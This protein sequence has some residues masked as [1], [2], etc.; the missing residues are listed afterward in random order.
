MESKV[1]ELLRSEVKRRMFEECGPRIRQCVTQLTDS[2]IWYRP[3]E[4]SNSIGNLVLHLSGNIRQWICAGLGKEPDIRRRQ[5]EF[6]AKEGLTGTELLEIFEAVL[7]DSRKVIDQL[8]Y[9]A[10]VSM[11]DVQTFY[12]NGVSILV[13]VTEHLSYH[14]GQIAYIT[15]M[16]L[17][18]PLDFYAG[19]D[20]E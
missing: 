7:N 11:H 16:L 17:G 8:P 5:T 20:L 9:E 10:F 6:D 4:E 1:T 13:H 14:T 15:K 3:N 2:Q 18:K 12:E 19:I